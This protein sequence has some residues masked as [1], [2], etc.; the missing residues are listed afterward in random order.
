[1]NSSKHNQD[2]HH[3]NH[4][5]TLAV[6]TEIIPYPGF[7]NAFNSNSNRKFSEIDFYLGPRSECGSEWDLNK[8]TKDYFEKNNK[9]FLPD[10]CLD[11]KYLKKQN[12]YLS[13]RSHSSAI[14]YE[15]DHKSL[16]LS[17]N[18]P[19]S[20][21]AKIKSKLSFTAIKNKISSKMKPQ[22]QI[23]IE[24]EP[25]TNDN[26]PEISQS[27]IKTIFSKN[28]LEVSRSSRK[29]SRNSSI[30]TLNFL[31]DT[32]PESQEVSRNSSKSEV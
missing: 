27:Q 29:N 17:E 31:V 22:V 9:N 30:E 26:N 16:S 1:M 23:K 4:Q 28:F 24:Q 12:N 18:V 10:Y 15:Y 20:K 25:D 19:D 21:I 11:D 14:F 3:H 13:R 32:K 6:S 5:G 2:R 8:K 7:Y